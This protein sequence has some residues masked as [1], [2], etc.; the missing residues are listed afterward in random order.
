MNV[1]FAVVAVSLL[2]VLPAAAERIALDAAGLNAE[3]T[4]V[5]TG[6][7]KAVYS[8]DV[9]TALYGAGTIET[10]SVLE[11]EVEAVEKG[12]GIKPKDII[13]ARCWN[14]KRRGK[15]GLRPIQLRAKAIG[16]CEESPG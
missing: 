3:S 16:R 9:E 7:V 15:D 2:F 11:I 4:H 14:L 8:R 1:R 10:Q 13:Y 6:R 12:D 5:I